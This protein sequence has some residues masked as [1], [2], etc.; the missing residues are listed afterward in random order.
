MV[1]VA[2]L[3]LSTAVASPLAETTLNIAAAYLPSS[4]SGEFKENY[5]AGIGGL[6]GFNY[7]LSKGWEAGL[8]TG[9]LGWGAQNHCLPELLRDC[10]GVTM[11]VIPF[12]VTARRRFGNDPETR[13]YLAAHFGSYRLNWSYEDELNSPGRHVSPESD[14]GFGFR[15]GILSPLSKHVSLDL[16]LG[17]NHAWTDDE[18]T[19][20]LSLRAGLDIRTATR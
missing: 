18:A 9:Y 12:V 8:T 7:G 2:V 14:Y 1:L 16:A 3:L 10:G 13:P 19:R 5:G 4:T 20:F 17:Y 15:V 11:G 6:I